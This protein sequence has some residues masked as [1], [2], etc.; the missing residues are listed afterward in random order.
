MILAGTGFDSPQLRRLRDD[1]WLFDAEGNPRAAL[2]GLSLD[3]L[4]PGYPPAHALA[5]LLRR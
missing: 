5:R 3:D 4:A 1:A 2:E